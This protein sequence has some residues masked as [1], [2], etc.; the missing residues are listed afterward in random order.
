[1][2]KPNGF[3]V[4]TKPCITAVREEGDTCGVANGP[5][6]KGVVS[7]ELSHVFPFKYDLKTLSH[8]P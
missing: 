5:H 3:I 8:L 7:G 4:L 1:M 6:E 2:S